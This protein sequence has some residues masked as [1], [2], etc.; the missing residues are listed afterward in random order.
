MG[1]KKRGKKGKKSK[2][3]KSIFFP[4]K[5]EWLAKRISIESPEKAKRSAETL[6]N[7]LER[8]RLGNMKIG[9]KRA[10]TIARGLQL[11]GTRAEKMLNKK[12]LSAKERRELR[13]VAKIYKEAA[14]E[15]WEIYREEYKT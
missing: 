6:L 2:N 5:H 1:R 4:P 11:A 13:E 15:A 7:A 3:K 8:G 9:Q 10:A 14:D 12:N